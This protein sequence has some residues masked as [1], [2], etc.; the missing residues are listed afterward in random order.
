MHIAASALSDI[1]HHA[2]ET[3]PRECCGLLVG[4]DAL[5]DESVRTSNLEPGVNRFLVDPAGH[6]ALIKRLRGTG[7]EIVGAYH[8][9]PRSEAVPSASDLAEA[10]SAAFL[11]VI[12][13]LVDPDR[14]VARAYRLLN[15]GAAELDIVLD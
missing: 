6:F 10:V 12:V 11:Y 3:A 13:S 14:P 8:S 15:D 7:R 9:H 4:T 5:V 2:R 1:V